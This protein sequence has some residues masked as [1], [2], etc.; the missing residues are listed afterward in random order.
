MNTLRLLSCL[1]AFAILFSGCQKDEEPVANFDFS[2]S[3]CVTPC[4]VQFTNA[5]LGTNNVYQWDFG[6]GGASTEENPSHEYAL[7]GTWT[8]TLNVSNDAGFSQI[9]KD[10]EV[11]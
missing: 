4:A 9:K 8:V 2:N 3:L 10:I 11:N 5:S 1:F 7:N 6:D